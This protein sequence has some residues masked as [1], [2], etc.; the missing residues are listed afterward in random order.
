[1]TKRKA[2]WF[3][4]RASDNAILGCDRRW[5]RHLCPEI[6]TYSSAGRAHKYGLRGAPGTAYAVYEDEDLNIAGQIFKDNTMTRDTSLAS[7]KDLI[8][9]GTTVAYSAEFCRSIGCQTGELPTMRGF[10]E[11]IKEIGSS[12]RAAVVRWSNG[13][14]YPI[15]INN[16]CIPGPNRKFCAC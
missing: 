15:N 1:M 8:Q 12:L 9:V 13:D 16:L 10:V 6:K 2:V 14:R 3:V 11:E 7:A 4:R 5:Y